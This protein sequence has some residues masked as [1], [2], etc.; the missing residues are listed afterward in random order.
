MKTGWGQGACRGK[1]AAGWSFAS[2]AWHTGG[3]TQEGEAHRSAGGQALGFR[4]VGRK[5]TECKS[6]YQ[7]WYHQHLETVGF[8]ESRESNTWY[9]PPIS[10]WSYWMANAHLQKVLCTEHCTSNTKFVAPSWPNSLSCSRRLISHL[11][12]FLLECPAPTFRGTACSL[13]AASLKST[14]DLS[15]KRSSIKLMNINK[16]A[17]QI[18]KWSKSMFRT[19]PVVP[20][21]LVPS[22]S[23]ALKCI[24][25][26]TE[27]FYWDRLH[28]CFVIWKIT[29]F[30]GIVTC[31]IASATIPET[32]PRPPAAS[33]TDMSCYPR[34]F[35]GR[36]FYRLCNAQALMFA[37]SHPSNYLKREKNDFKTFQSQVLLFSLAR[38]TQVRFT[39]PM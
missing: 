7:E 2:A 38:S 31:I 39:L 8:L 3:K 37:M 29:S 24:P 5:G 11:L 26:L 28:C 18:L 27:G 22:L 16:Y 6:L 1:Q 21:K 19:H 23:T 12:V 9:Y 13:P 17:S 35:R 14:L 10:S 30:S 15:E 32:S 20:L 36:F 33:L 34:V 4:L 25:I